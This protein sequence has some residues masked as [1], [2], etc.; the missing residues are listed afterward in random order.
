MSI[1][2]EIQ[3]KLEVN[4]YHIPQPGTLTSSSHLLFRT[5]YPSVNFVVQLFLVFALPF[6][7]LHHCRWILTLSSHDFTTARDPNVPYH[8]ASPPSL[9]G[10]MNEC[11][12][13]VG[14]DTIKCIQSVRPCIFSR[15]RTLPR[16]HLLQALQNA[17]FASRKLTMSPSQSARRTV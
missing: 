9:R 17:M 1:K 12:F 7:D 10:S 5:L 11:P 16:D 8:H 13:S 3:S 6:C 4:E 2:C 15:E 14:K